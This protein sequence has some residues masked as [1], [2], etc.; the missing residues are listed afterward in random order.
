MLDLIVFIMA[1]VIT[2]VPGLYL[3][4]AMTTNGW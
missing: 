3:I 1:L 2:I 4:R